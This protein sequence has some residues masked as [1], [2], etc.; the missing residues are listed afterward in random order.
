MRSLRIVLC[1]VALAPG[2]PAETCQTAS[3]IDPALRSQLR[4][5]AMEYFNIVALGDPAAL[6]QRST[7]EVARDPESIK[8]LLKENAGI[9][10]GA[11]AEPRNVYLLDASGD[12]AVLESAQF[13]CGVFNPTVDL[14]TG[15]RLTDLVPA[16]YA[17]VILDVTSARAPHFFSFLLRQDGSQWRIAGMVAR[18]R[19]IAGHD[20]A[21]FWQQARDYKTKG[22][23]MNAWFHYLA[24]REL[25]A[26][27]PFMS[28]TKLE[29][30]FDEVTRAQ[31]SSLPEKQPLVLTGAENKNV[32]V[33]SLYIVPNDAGDGLN[34]AFRY[35]V[36]D[37]SDAKAVLLE[38]NA[39]MQAVLARFPEF[40]DAYGSII[41]IAVAPDGQESGSI[42]A[43]KELK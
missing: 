24:A 12:K 19:Q 8:S 43:I 2:A 14:R 25:S 26:P 39:A 1:L 17:L 5:T 9:L 20:M 21:W 27:V 31:P 13:L 32:E 30:F 42:L 23:G 15:F 4:N 34:L 16:K 6:G 29:T 10:T 11:T 36:A 3:E 22:Q 7:P 33:A 40:R 28:T 18:A 35:M 38:N 41:A 37:I